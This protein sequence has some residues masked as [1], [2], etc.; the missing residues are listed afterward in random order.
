MES[1]ARRTRVQAKALHFGGFWHPK[2]ADQVGA[3]FELDVMRRAEG[4]RIAPAFGLP[5]LYR[6]GPPV[7][8]E[9]KACALVGRQGFRDVHHDHIDGTTVAF[10]MMIWNVFALFQLPV[11]PAMPVFVVLSA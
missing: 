3:D 11:M 6:V 10:S 5:A 9:H 2:A 4:I 8:A 7:D 1:Y